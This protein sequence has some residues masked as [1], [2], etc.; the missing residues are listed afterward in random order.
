MMQTSLGHRLR[1]LRAERQLSLRQAAAR[2]GVVKETISD[3]E[4]GVSHPQDVTLAKL[5]HAY[6]VPVEDLLEEPVPLAEAPETGAP[7]P[8]EVDELAKIVYRLEEWFS[9]RRPL[10]AYDR[11]LNLTPAEQR[12]LAELNA[13]IDRDMNRLRDFPRPLARIETRLDGSL[14]LVYLRP[15]IPEE[16]AK[17]EAKYPDAEVVEAHETKET[18]L[19]NETEDTSLVKTEFV[20]YAA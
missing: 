14:K 11:V 20:L 2:A 13:N 6:D 1:L 18:D 3:I 16:R 9:E 4:R 10:I 19:V 12:R 8:G 5:A 7:D 15:P 17:L